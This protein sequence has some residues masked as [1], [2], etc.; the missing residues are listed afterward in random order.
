MVDLDVQDV[1]L[2]VNEIELFDDG[3][4]LVAPDEIVVHNHPSLL[5]SLSIKGLCLP[6]EVKFLQ[7][8]LV[9][10]DMAAPLF[11]EQDGEFVHICYFTV[12]LDSLLLLVSLGYEITGWSDDG[13]PTNLNDPMMIQQFIRL[14]DA[15]DDVSVR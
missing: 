13:V 5:P 4:T 7:D 2:D 1:E 14:G 15:V 10:S 12:D 6:E 8:R 9:N 3:V 11:V